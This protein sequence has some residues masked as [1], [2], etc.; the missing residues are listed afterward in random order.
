MGLEY[1]VDGFHLM[2]VGIPTALLAT[3]P[4]LGNTKLFCQDVPCHEIYGKEEIPVY[5]NLAEYDERLHV[6]DAPFPQER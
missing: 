4:M 2:G 6:C 5:R 1:H 3:E